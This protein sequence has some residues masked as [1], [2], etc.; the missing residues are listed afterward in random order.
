MLLRL[1]QS[2]FELKN[3]L[4]IKALKKIKVH[5]CLLLLIGYGYFGI[6][7]CPFQDKKNKHLNTKRHEQNY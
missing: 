5:F 2:W 6:H 4:I 7:I 1:T 3:E